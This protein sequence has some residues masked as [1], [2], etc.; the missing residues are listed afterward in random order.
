MAYFFIPM[1]NSTS[2]HESWYN[3]RCAIGSKVYFF[4]RSCLLLGGHP[5]SISSEL[6]IGGCP[7]GS[8]A[9]WCNLSKLQVGWCRNGCQKGHWLEVIL[10]EMGKTDTKVISKKWN[11][12]CLVWVSTPIK[13]SVWESTTRR[14]AKWRKCLLRACFIS[15]NVQNHWKHR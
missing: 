15:T 1:K 9:R 12:L 7:L 3:H 14:D 5:H 10:Q 8:Q 13:D 2:Y 4:H 11:R 6:N